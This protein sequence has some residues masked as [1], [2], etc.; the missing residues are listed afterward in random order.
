[1]YTEEKNAAREFLAEYGDDMLV[2]NTLEEIHNGYYMHSDRWSIVY[3]MISDN[4]PSYIRSGV[5]TGL[6]YLVEDNDI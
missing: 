5:V 1:M 6:V 3:D 4:Y 2:I